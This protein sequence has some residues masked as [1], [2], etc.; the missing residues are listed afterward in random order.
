MS[1]GQFVLDISGF[2]AI[3]RSCLII[4]YNSKV[5]VLKYIKILPYFI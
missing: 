2:C 3:M 5:R 4:P 1:L